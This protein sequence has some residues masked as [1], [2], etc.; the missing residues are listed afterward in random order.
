MDLCDELRNV[1]QVEWLRPL[2]VKAAD[3]IESLQKKITE[4]ENERFMRDVIGKA[5]WKQVCKENSDMREALRNI[6]SIEH[7]YIP[8]PTA[9]AEANL[10]GILNGCVSLAE[11]ALGEKQ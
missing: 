3:K 6:A 2:C 10:W 7:E 1:S 9:P 11:K 8:P 4:M 5:N